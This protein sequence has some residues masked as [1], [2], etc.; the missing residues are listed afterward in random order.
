MDVYHKALVKLYQETNGSEAHLVYFIDLVKKL[1]FMG[2]YD[3]ILRTL[4]GQGWI[5]ETGKDNWV[6]ITHWG[7]KEAQKSLSGEG[8]S[9]QTVKKEV[10]H[11]IS[12]ARDFINLLDNLAAD[13]SKENFAAVEK[14]VSELNEAI[15]NLKSHIK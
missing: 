13:T 8:E 10:I 11:I 2:S 15:D 7:V 3:D 12:E 4:S 6:K 14:K 1:G 5:A 9:E